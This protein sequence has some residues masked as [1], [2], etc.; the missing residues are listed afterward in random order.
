MEN[1]KK[2]TETPLSVSISIEKIQEISFKYN[3]EYDYSKLSNNKIELGFKNKLKPLFDKN[4][5][6]VGIGVCY[7]DSNEKKELAE[8]EIMISFGLSNLNQFVKEENDSLQV[9]DGDLIVNLLS[10]GIG[11]LRGI[12]YSKFKGMPLEKYPLP[13]IS[14]DVLKQMVNSLPNKKKK[15]KE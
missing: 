5:L 7:R 6:D 1:K 14:G 8:L 15:E 4:I 10:I 11:T 2:K 3:A 9:N 12:L 13:L